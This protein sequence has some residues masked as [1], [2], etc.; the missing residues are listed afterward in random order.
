M[1][2]CLSSI[3]LIALRK[4][5][6][7]LASRDH[8]RRCRRCSALLGAV[9]P[10]V[11]E[12]QAALFASLREETQPIQRL[13]ENK[14]AAG[15]VVNKSPKE[16]PPVRSRTRTRTILLSQYLGEALGK[17]EW[18]LGSLAEQAQVPTSLLT[19]FCND[20]FD[21]THRSDTEAVAKVLTAL[22]DDPEEIARGPLWESL[23]RT[24]GGMIE[25]T[26]TTEMLAGSSFAGVSEASR[27]SDL[28]RDQVE[29][30]DSEPARKQAAELYL[31]DV[32]AAL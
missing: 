24:P 30:D 12:R 8:A 14:M 4:G 21:L 22:G 19:A 28:F 25:A 32:L 27:E 7:S 1:D 29:I 3:E 10:R 23:L 31:A 17:E 18:D 26:G 13:I 9:T 16:V 20:V 2:N 15:K 5:G 11:L 6:G